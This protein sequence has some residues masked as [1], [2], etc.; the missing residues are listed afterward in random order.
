M[1]DNG[2]LEE[3]F[4][5]QA[6]AENQ[7]YWTATDNSTNFAIAAHSKHTYEDALEYVAELEAAYYQADVVCEECPVCED[8]DEC[9]EC[10]VCDEEGDDIET[11]INFDFAGLIPEN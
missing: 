2:E 11:Q 4:W 7:H 10:P 8:C 3:F 9:E 6:G 5:T 1:H